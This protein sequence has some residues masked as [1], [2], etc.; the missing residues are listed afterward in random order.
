MMMIELKQDKATETYVTQ[1]R[2]YMDNLNI[3]SLDWRESHTKKIE[4]LCLF[5]PSW[6]EDPCLTKGNRPW[7]IWICF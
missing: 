2:Q 1:A 4:C 7:G 6:K 3:Y 5:V